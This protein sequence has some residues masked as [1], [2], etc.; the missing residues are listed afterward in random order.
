MTAGATTEQALVPPALTALMS[1]DEAS[2][3]VLDYL[4]TLIPMSFWAVTAHDAEG[5]RQVYLHLRD[6]SGRAAV[7]D[8]NAWSESFCQYMVAGLAPQLA[9]DIRAVPRYAAL[10]AAAG[11]AVGAYVGVPIR[12]GDGELFGTLCASDP[13]RQESAVLERHAPLLQL[14]ATLLG[15]IL[16]GERLQLDA[17]EREATLRWRAF[18][19]ELTSLPN[20]ALFYDRLEHALALHARDQR[21]VA[22]LTLDVDDFKAVNDAFGHGGGD[23]LLVGL[24]RRLQ[25][26]VRAGDTLARMGGDEFAVLLEPSGGRGGLQ[27]AQRVAERVMAA[28]DEPFQVGGQRIKVGVS[29]GVAALEP[30][31]HGVGAE[32]LLTQADVALYTAKRGGKFQSTVYQPTMRLPEARDLQLREPLREA[33][34]NGE[35]QEVY[36]PVVALDTLTVVGVECLARWTHQ[37][38]P[39]GPDVFIPLA[40]RS[41]LLPALTTL[42]VGRACAQLRQWRRTLG[43]DRLR[44][45]VNVPPGLLKDPAFPGQLTAQVLGA[46]VHPRQLT[47]EI[48]EDALLDD[49]DAAAV[50]A[51]EL[52]AAGFR[53]ALDD[54]GTGYSS[55]LHLRTIPLDV[56]KIDRGF[57]S[58]VDTNP[59]TRRFMQALLTM[60]H[61]LGLRVVVEGVERVSQADVLRELGATHAQGY[62]YARPAPADQLDLSTLR[63][64]PTPEPAAS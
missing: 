23:A 43:H 45:A 57:T 46:G 33:I 8:S 32:V 25:A 47:L 44:V 20:R 7:G 38:R 3:R 56:V 4:R 9:A 59:R 13:D 24:S 63:P 26:A 48:T 1:F 17:R 30:G 28:L 37:G 15:Q 49:P 52:H 11:L 31:T 55:L 19:D 54:F 12:T 62:L 34:E 41:R 29:V 27:G 58:D 64:R 16:T 53:L 14:L 6:Q 36:Q 5:D 21:P 42:M 39:V 2:E 60:G 18:H 40:A 10:S 22:V 35:I 51:E 50:I 61:E